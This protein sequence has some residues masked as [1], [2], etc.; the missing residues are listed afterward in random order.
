M[1]GGPAKIDLHPEVTANTTLVTW[2]GFAN[3]LMH[4]VGSK[5]NSTDMCCD[6]NPPNPSTSK[7]SQQTRSPGK[8]APCTKGQSQI[9]APIHWLSV[10]GKGD[11]AAMPVLASITSL[12]PPR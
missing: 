2:Q 11:E 6:Q 10:T 12:N 5:G 8:P 7:E 9:L 4:F 1:P 3:G